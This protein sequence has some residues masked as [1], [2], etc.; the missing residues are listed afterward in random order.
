M[1]VGI[2]ELNAEAAEKAWQESEEGLIIGLEPI[3][4]ADARGVDRTVYLNG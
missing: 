2:V 1:D 3:E 4:F